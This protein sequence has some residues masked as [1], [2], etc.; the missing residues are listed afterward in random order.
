MF[1]YISLVPANNSY[2][3]S[4]AGGVMLAQEFAL[5]QTPQPTSSPQASVP[6][7]GA[8]KP[9]SRLQ[10]FA[11]QISAVRSLVIDTVILT[12]VIALIVAVFWE[13]RRK[14]A[15]IDPIIVP[16]E[17]AKNGYT[18]DVVA[19]QLVT[20]IRDLQIDARV[21]ARREESFE[22]SGAQI[23][24]TVPTAG[25]SYRAIVRY[26]RQVFGRPEQRVQGE[27]IRELG[28]IR[29]V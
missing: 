23:D 3:V 7:V 27:I 6:P 18:P 14:S 22:L 5:I 12:I 1:I 10:N 9:K 16:P 25:I 21:K 19:Q 11:D 26:M 20:E 15:I 8:E 17:I 13:L 29:M 24:F 2:L 28:I 4:A